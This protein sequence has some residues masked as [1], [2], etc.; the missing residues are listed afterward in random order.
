MLACNSST[1]ESH[2]FST[3]AE[4][5]VVYHLFSILA[6]CLYCIHAVCPSH[7]LARVRSELLSTTSPHPLF[8]P[9]PPLSLSVDCS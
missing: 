8:L 2:T 3:L 7:V 9:S 5:E 1:R 4:N 6:A